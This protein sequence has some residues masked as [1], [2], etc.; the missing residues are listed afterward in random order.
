MT[1]ALGMTVGNRKKNSGIS[2]QKFRIFHTCGFSE[3]AQ[4]FAGALL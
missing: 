1:I 3:N 2:F 4:Y